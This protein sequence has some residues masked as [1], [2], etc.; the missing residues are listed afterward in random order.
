MCVFSFT[1]F[2]SSNPFSQHYTPYLS[3]ALHLSH[4]VPV[5]HST[6]PPPQVSDLNIEH[7]RDDQAH[8]FQSLFSSFGGTF[9]LLTGASAVSLLELAILFYFFLASVISSMICK[10]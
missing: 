4:H 6:Y 2:L 9:G 10:K 5:H 7:I 1:H 8:T 3:T